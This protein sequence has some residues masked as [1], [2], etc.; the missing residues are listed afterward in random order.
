M[1]PHRIGTRTEWL[2]ERLE[3]LAAE[4]EL[5]RRADELA[6]RRKD[7][8]WARVEKEYVF[9]TRKERR[10]QRNYS[11]VDRSF[12]TTTSCSARRGPQDAPPARCMRKVSTVPSSLSISAT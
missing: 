6:R 11:T 5:T 2:Q 7:L 1:S 12:S 4:K 10:R 8:P 3:L 9:E